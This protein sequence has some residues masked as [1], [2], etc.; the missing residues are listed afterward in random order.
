MEEVLEIISISNQKGGVGKST[1]ASNLAAQF[2]RY[3]YRTLVVDTD[4]QASSTDHAAT[5]RATSKEK[6]KSIPLYRT[7]SILKD[8]EYQLE[9]F[10]DS[11]DIVIIDTSGRDN[12]IA[13]A[14]MMASDLVLVPVQPSAY[15][16]WG[17]QVTFKT[18]K[19][20]KK[21]NPDVKTYTFYNK[22]RQNTSISKELKEISA[23]IK[24]DFSINFLEATISFREAYNHASW[25]GVSVTELTGSRRCSQSVIEMRKFYH[26]VCDKLNIPIKKI[27]Q[28]I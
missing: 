13:D 7:V 4:P 21:R 26:E 20:I 8:I 16:M 28:E 25:E 22:V 18:L 12:E 5:R 3:G 17:S 15:D 24:E 11:F 10:V 6:K 23:Q 14:S 1:L 2:Q 19:S 9:G 27:D